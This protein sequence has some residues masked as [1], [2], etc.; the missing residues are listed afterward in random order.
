MKNLKRV[1]WDNVGALLMVLLGIVSM[2]HHIQ[3]NGLYFELLFE[4]LIYCVFALGAK[5]VILDI[6]THPQNWKW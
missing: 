2:I 1:K 3:L 6:R 5:A 4:I